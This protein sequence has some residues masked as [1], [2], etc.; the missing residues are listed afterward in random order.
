[1]VAA[2]DWRLGSCVIPFLMF[3]SLFLFL[4]GEEKRRLGLGFR[5][6]WRWIFRFRYQIWCN[7]KRI[8]VC[9]ANGR[10]VDLAKKM[11]YGLNKK[12]DRVGPHT[13]VT[14]SPALTSHTR[15]QK[16]PLN[17]HRINNSLVQCYYNNNIH[18]RNVQITKNK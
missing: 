13:L 14:Y 1:M 15:K 9:S 8:R 10:F 4:K 3:F 11:K 18:A 17:T 16:L 6:L 12:K 2:A 7:T 5:N